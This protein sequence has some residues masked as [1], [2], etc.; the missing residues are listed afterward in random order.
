MMRRVVAVGVLAVALLVGCGSQ[1]HAP[2]VTDATVSHLDWS[3]LTPKDW[4]AMK[5]FQGT[6]LS[7]MSDGDPRADGL[8]KLARNVWNN[9][10][11][12]EALDGKHGSM[13][14]Y[15]VPLGGDI[16]HIREFLLVPYFG[17]CIHTPP[18]PSNQIVHVHVAG[19]GIPMGGWDGMV[20]VSGELTIARST[21][22]M[23]TAG[24]SMSAEVVRPF[25]D[26][27]Q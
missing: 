21:T 9:A 23:G 6:D 7:E 16:E 19:P 13:T 17:A 15:V 10:P 22:A 8:L 12:V 14:G 24:Y 1:E 26:T 11:V 18:P 27:L 20:E 25:K 2:A 3:M 4:D 5:L